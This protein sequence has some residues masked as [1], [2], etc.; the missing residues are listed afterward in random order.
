VPG[1]K[2]IQP[3]LQPEALLLKVQRVDDAILLWSV[4]GG[5]VAGYRVPLSAGLADRLS[6]EKVAT[7]TAADGETLAAVLQPVMDEIDRAKTL[8]LI[9]DGAL[10]FL[11]WAA[12]PVG[13]TMLAERMPLVFLSSL[14]HLKWATATRNL[15]SAR[16]LGV[17][18]PP[19]KSL[20]EKFSSVETLSGDAA[21]GEAF[22]ERWGH[23]GVVNID[24][25][26]HLSP[27]AVALSLTRRENR[28]E[29]LFLG[30]LLREP[31]DAHLFAL[32][33]VRPRFLPES[34]MSPT[35]PL[36]RA[37]T[38]KG[39]PGVL[40]FTGPRDEAL[41]AELLDLFYRRLPEGHPAAALQLAQVEVARRHPES[42]AWAGYRFYGYAGMAE[43]EK[44]AFARA[45]FDANVER[46]AKAFLAK[47]W[48][49]AIDQL[50]KA[51][52][53]VRFLDDPSPAVKL[54][55]TL[56]QA[57][58]NGGDYLKAIH[59]QEAILPVVEQAEDPEQLAEALYFLG[60][61]E[62]RA[63]NFPK[64]VEHLKRALAIYEE[65]EILDRLAESYSTLGIVEENA[66]DYGQALE[67]FSQSLRINEEIGEELNRGRELRRIG[68]IYYLR[69]SRYADARKY[70]SD[71]YSLFAGLDEKEQMAESLL[72]LGLVSEKQG[73]FDE[74]L[75]YYRQAEKIAGDAEMPGTLSKAL[76]YQ[77][78]SYWFQG[79]YQ[80]AF[81]YQKNALDIAEAQGDL[82]QQ[83]HIYNTLGLI[84][85]TLNDSARALKSMEK[86]LE[87]AQ[88]VDSPLD[89]ASAYNNIG[90][91][92]R[93]NKAY[94]TSIEFFSKALE[95]DIEL[96]SKWGQG[97]THRNLGMSTL[98]LGRFDEAEEH[99]EQ[100]VAL[101]GEIGNHTNLVKS[102]LERG[103][104]ALERKQFDASIAVFQETAQRAEAINLPE[105]RWRALRG[106]GVALVAGGRRAEAAKRYREA[107]AVVDRLR[108]AIKIEEFQ[109]GFLTDKQDVYKELVLLLL[110]MGRVEEAFNYAEKAKS[111]SFIDLLGNQKISLK[112]DVS[113]KLY[114]RL[115]GGKQKIRL[116]EDALAEARGKADED[117]ATRLA[118]ELRAARDS[119]QD[120]LIAA[121]E[122][123]PQISSFVTVDAIELGELRELLEEGT[124]LIEYLV[125]ER[126]LVAWVVTKG[127]IEVVR[128]AV[129]EADLNAGI[130]DYRKR[131]QQLAPVEEVAER[132]HGWLIGPLAERVAGARVLGIVP[133]GHLHY[134]SFAS[135]KDK[136]AYLVERHPLFYS[137]SASVLKYTFERKR[138][139]NGRAKVLALGNPDLGDFNY[140]L[141]L[142]EME[143]NAIRWDF[144][145][146]DV[147]TREKATE[148]WLKEHIG[149]YQI[150]HIASHGEF[151]PV[152]PLFSSLKLTKDETADG[153]FEVNEVFSLK[154]NA[155]IVTLSACQ[156]GLG[157]I[158]GGD[159]LVGLNRAF[160][161]AGT[162]SILSSL[163]RVSDIS[164]AVLIKHFYRNFAHGDK[165]ESLRNAQ[166]LVKKFYPHPSYWAGFSLSGDHR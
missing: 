157:D 122:E 162:H 161:Y 112:N 149:E 93:Q 55:Q 132:L 1:L 164:T 115:V 77:A 84:H 65:Y 12:A 105:V 98:R 40:L 66:L 24:T 20:A 18:S 83:A 56:A 28:F 15:Y 72:E 160:I 5:P 101:S 78:N 80:P 16:Y 90:L 116:I 22:R 9:A 27:G 50:E 150:I 110:D 88:A 44:N 91:V 53:L 106:E 118:G 49:S 155:D 166:L 94:E 104:L 87:L 142:A 51:L 25:P 145:E 131:I 138:E 159:E 42:R 45:H 36:I 71:A 121:K 113:Q 13:R 119:Y 139:I 86:S 163:W 59:Y 148:S 158:K 85:W 95:K 60:I 126:E 38:F 35:A 58:Y 6:P 76:L 99:I 135:L 114:D 154:I 96:K 4:G 62:S 79:A 69:L 31:Y 141:P 17:E 143:A 74:A 47:D 97:Y 19:L 48:L 3:L 61:L 30:D 41:H 63:E 137:P 117:A 129:A 107:V 133:H 127:G 130:A 128:T 100:A 151:D 14:S 144:P 64:A 2:E 70:F 34:G 108:A 29:R 23:F 103:H 146:V 165:A 52:A 153:N 43:D 81:R 68:R 152:N 33:D 75:N 124:A 11:P 39:Y 46:G 102:L 92:H 7:P 21:T 111:R 147:L 140:D 156:T 67:A 54:N 10:E 26:A 125:T 73:S 120:E 134:L 37:L 123:S 89:V 8:Y 82:R 57:A 136:E 32:G 109:N